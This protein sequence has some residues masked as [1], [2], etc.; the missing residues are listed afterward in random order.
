MY[1]FFFRKILKPFINV[2]DERV[3]FP[4]RELPFHSEQFLK[5]TERAKFSDNITIVGAVHHIIAFNHIDMIELFQNGN[6]LLEQSQSHFRCNRL[7]FDDFDCHS[8]VIPTINCFENLAETPRAQFP[9]I[10]ENIILDFLTILFRSALL[11]LLFFFIDH[12][13]F[14]SSGTLTFIKAWNVI[15]FKRSSL[16][17]AGVIV[18]ASICGN[19]LCLPKPKGKICNRYKKWFYI[20]LFFLYSSILD[21]TPNGESK[22]ISSHLWESP[23][24]YKLDHIGTWWRVRKNLSE[25][26]LRIFFHWTSNMD[27]FKYKCKI[28]HDIIDDII[29]IKKQ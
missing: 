6:F 22:N 24:Q 17:C 16:I 25:S 10:R 20:Q 12:S 19:K 29:D 27:S 28:K 15:T 13:R 18:L 21:S 26:L 1:N 23:L 3:N 8:I 7:D 14:Q 9:I 5:V 2:V 11:L 4:L